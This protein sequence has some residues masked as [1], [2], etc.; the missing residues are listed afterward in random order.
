MS[1]RSPDA[2]RRGGPGSYEAR[3]GP[4][5]WYGL[6]QGTAALSGGDAF[7]FRAGTGHALW[8]GYV[9]EVTSGQAR[10]AP[11]R[12]CGRLPA[13]LHCSC[14]RLHVLCVGACSSRTASRWHMVR[15]QSHDSPGLL[16]RLDAR[17][18]IRVH[19]IA[20]S[21]YRRHSMPRT[22]DIF[23][24]AASQ[25]PSP[26]PGDL[27]RWFGT[28]RRI[29]RHEVGQYLAL[30]SGSSVLPGIALYKYSNVLS[31]LNRVLVLILRLRHPRSRRG[32]TRGTRRAS[33]QCQLPSCC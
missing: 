29:L 28:L 6:L 14:P 22:Q 33:L 7:L 18:P 31:R 10:A 9:L 27:D 26:G 13:V 32:I 2:Q 30:S 23:P 16:W 4:P 24:V 1:A 3:A 5:A 12:T 17:P 20:Q 8:T 15:F 19:I 25:Q 11:R 21:A